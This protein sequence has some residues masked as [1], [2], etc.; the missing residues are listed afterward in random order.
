MKLV[1]LFVFVAFSTSSAM[2]KFSNIIE[3]EF[4]TFKVRS[5]NNLFY[6]HYSDI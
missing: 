3:D 1:V 4:E 6:A 5:G 2:L